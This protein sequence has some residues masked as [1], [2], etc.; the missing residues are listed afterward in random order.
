MIF[1]QQAMM[2]DAPL[3]Q[4][5]RRQ[6]VHFLDARDADDHSKMALYHEQLDTLLGQ[7]I[8]KYPRVTLVD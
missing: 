3:A 8:D 7:Y 1:L 6:L 4:E 5:I 2:H